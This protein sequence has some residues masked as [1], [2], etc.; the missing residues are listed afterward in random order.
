MKT[1][2]LHPSSILDKMSVPSTQK[3]WVITSD[4]KGFDGLVFKEAPVPKLGENEVLVKLHAA[5]LNYRDL[6][7]AKVSSDESQVS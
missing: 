7:I 4:E 6:A 3:Q 5:S 1:N 2:D